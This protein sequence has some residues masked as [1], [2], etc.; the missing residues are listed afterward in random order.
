MQALTHFVDHH[1]P[2]EMREALVDVVRRN[3]EA[4]R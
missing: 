1:P 4:H 3:G 2:G